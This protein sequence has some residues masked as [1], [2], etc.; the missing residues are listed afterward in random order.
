[1]DV[2]GRSANAGTGEVDDDQGLLGIVRRVEALGRRVDLL[3]ASEADLALL[4]EA[5]EM[6]TSHSMFHARV[7]RRTAWTGTRV[8]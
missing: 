8:R 6:D 1:M 4:A 5:H 3:V 7:V 2:G